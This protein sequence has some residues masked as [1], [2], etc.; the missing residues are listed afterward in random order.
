MPNIRNKQ[1]N[2]CLLDLRGIS[3]LSALKYLP[4]INLAWRFRLNQVGTF[5][6]T[7][8]A[9]MK[10]KPKSIVDMVSVKKSSVRAS[11]NNIPVIAEAKI[12]F[13]SL[14]KK[15]G[16]E[17]V[18]ELVFYIFFSVSQNLKK[19]LQIMVLST[20]FCTSFA[21]AVAENECLNAITKY[22]QLYS[23]PKGLLKAVSKVESEYNPLA[24]NDGLKQHKFKSKQEAIERITYLQSI[25]KTNFDVGCMQINYR[26]HHKNFTSV[27]EMLDVDWNVRYAASHL[28]GLYKEHE[29]WQIA[30]RR[31]HSY[32]PE[33]H[34]EYSRKIAIA[35]LKGD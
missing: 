23:I 15:L 28:Y 1:I 5:Q 17:S 10:Q 33:I 4:L 31:Y 13:L 14:L 9:L 21:S 25:G 16:I 8:I 6:Y 26:W 3:L 11:N 12:T 7:N 29:S 18:L 22:E 30:I 32:D 2:S 34:K 20:I 27:E 35:W 24:L 19:V